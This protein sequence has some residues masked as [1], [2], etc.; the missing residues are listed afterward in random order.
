MVSINFDGTTLSSDAV[1]NLTYNGRLFNDSF[2][3]GATLCKEFHLWVDKGAVTSHPTVVTIY[4][5]GT[6]F[7]T[8][9]IDSI[10]KGLDIFKA[11]GS[12]VRVAII[13]QLLKNPGMN[14]S[15]TSTYPV[16]TRVKPQRQKRLV[17]KSFSWYCMF[18]DLLQKYVK[19]ISG[20]NFVF[21]IMINFNLLLIN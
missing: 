4:D 9:H 6:L 20:M 7:A 10:E 18:Y 16:P 14:K 21:F 1:L 15:H 11:L 12:E 19:T 13:M 17:A 2:K 3:L 5:N 8:L